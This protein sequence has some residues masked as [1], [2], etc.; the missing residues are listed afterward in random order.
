MP[1]VRLKSGP[2]EFNKEGAG[3][4]FW[5]MRLKYASPALMN[6]PRTQGFTVER[7][8]TLENSKTPATSFTAG[9][10]IRVT[11]TIHNTKERRFVAVTDPIPAG[12]E[13]VEAWFATTSA[14]VAND[15]AKQSAR[16]MWWQRGGFDHI[17]RHD[18][19][20]E[21]FATRLSEGAHE[22]SYLV[23]ATT[24]GTF[25]AAPLRVE[26]MYA[27]EIFGRTASESVEIK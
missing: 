15:Q 12:T 25:T 13:P 9:D 3:T 16:A 7:K 27:P 8:Y 14:Q 5:L 26:E 24:S 23:R 17:E 1:I 2:V 18:D 10:M 11:I 4:L 6:E 21:L 20:V 22:F 19:R